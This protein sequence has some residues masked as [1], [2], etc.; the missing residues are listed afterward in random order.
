MWHPRLDRD[1]AHR[2]LR[3]MIVDVC[4]PLDENP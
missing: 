1:P 4:R 2:W 3:G